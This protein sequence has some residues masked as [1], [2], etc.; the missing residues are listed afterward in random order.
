MT[1]QLLPKI[2]VIL[3]THNPS[4]YLVEQIESINAQEGVEVKIYW[5]DDRSDD[6]SKARTRQILSLS[7]YVEV[8]SKSIGATS[9]F[10]NLLSETTEKYIAF[11]DQDDIWLPSKLLNQS[12]ALNSHTEY[13]ALTHS[14]PMIITK[15][16]VKQKK[17]ICTDHAIRTL[18]FE[19]CCQGCTLMINSKARELILDS[20]YQF[21]YW[22]DWW[23]LLLIASVG[24]V[25][26]SLNSE[27]LYRIHDKNTIGLPNFKKRIVNSLRKPPGYLMNQFYLLTNFINEFE[28]SP[29]LSSEIK[30]IMRMNTSSRK[31][32]L[33][34]A[35]I[36]PPRRK[37]YLE[38]IWRRILLVRQIP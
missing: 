10:F 24:K 16:G 35:F 1:D 32:R 29:N 34:L 17:S 2:A 25:E 20:P 13:P 15:R 18:I 5:S 6:D 7:N 26:T 9:N 4:E 37:N 21:A 12:Q 30:S 36:D 31:K 38:D 27:V 19:N 11:A 3:A 8:A 23:I 14:N 28:Q 33:I 22:H